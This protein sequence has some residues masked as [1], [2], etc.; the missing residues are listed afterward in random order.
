MSRELQ[1][2]AR[3]G[4]F[5]H[6]AL[7]YRGPD[8]FLAGTVPFITEGLDRGEPVAVAVPGPNLD[9][10]AKALHGRAGD[11]HLLDMTQAGRNPGRIIPGV[12]RAFADAYPDRRVRII[13]E[14]I[15][16]GRSAVEYPACV[17][18]EALINLAFADR[19]VTILCPYDAEQLSP[20]VLADAAATHPVLIDDT[21][22]V[23]SPDYAPTRVVADWNVPLPEAP[24][25]AQVLA[26]D[27]A[28]LTEP[29][30]AA[31][32]Y[33]MCAGLDRDRIPDVELAVNELATNAILHGGGS[34]TLRVWTEA[35][36]LVCEL[37]DRGHLTDPLVGRV[38]VRRATPGGRGM[39]LV[40]HLADLVRIYTTAAGTTLR[41][42]FALTR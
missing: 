30:L 16:P 18:H 12:L 8:D 27:D 34:G 13:G 23:P 7:F 26:F 40:N 14:P 41:V 28:T 2:A 29:R 1:D 3:G 31:Y 32:R 35:G 10:L 11:A 4:G 15:W 6:P 5:A 33:A 37:R 25:G 39:L 22:S 9:L 21:G 36:H 19:D 17:Q 42:Y 38:P 20:A 24:D